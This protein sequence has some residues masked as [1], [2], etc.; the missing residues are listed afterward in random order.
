MNDDG[1]GSIL[2]IS[3]TEAKSHK[4]ETSLGYGYGDD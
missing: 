1:D 3:S 4:Y 2:V